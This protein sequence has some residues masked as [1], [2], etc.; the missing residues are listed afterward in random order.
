MGRKKKITDIRIVLEDILAERI[1][2][3]DGE[4]EKTVG[5]L[6]ALVRAEINN[7]LKGSLP[8]IKSL[9]IRARDCRLFTRAKIKK[10]MMTFTEPTGDAGKIVRM[11]HQEQAALRRTAEKDG[12]ISPARK[13]Q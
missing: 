10:S 5:T 3:P 11:Y 2:I 12:R 9:F 7:A 8:S 6:E 13:R 1:T 4:G